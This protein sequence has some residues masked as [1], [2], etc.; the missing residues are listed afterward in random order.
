MA[1]KTIDVYSYGFE[2]GTISDGE[3][4]WSANRVRSVSYMQLPATFVGRKLTASATVSTGKTVQVDMVGYVT[5]SPPDTF[6]LCWYNSPYTFDLSSYQTTMYF[7]M[8][9]KYSDNSAITPSEITSCKVTYD[10]GIV[11][12]AHEGEYP[13]N[14]SAKPIA[15]MDFTRPFPLNLWRIDE[16]NDSYPH[17]DLQPGTQ[18]DFTRPFPLN[19]WRIDQSNDGYPYHD[20]QLGIL[21]YEPEPPPP[22]PTNPERANW[23]GH[24]FIRLNDIDRDKTSVMGYI[25][26]KADRAF[27]PINFK[28]ISNWNKSLQDLNNSYYQ[29]LGDDILGGLIPWE[30]ND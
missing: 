8:C 30:Y 23:L 28:N 21:T 18:T 15:Q 20:L 4:T 24:W 7:K 6:D 16:S 13:V 10:D 5:T 27:K 11:Y 29:M 2:Q 19:R 1:I 26:R 12:H 3:P 9:L 22:E 17:T 14:D 25:S